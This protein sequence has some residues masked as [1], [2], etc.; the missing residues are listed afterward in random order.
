MSRVPVP[1]RDPSLSAGVKRSQIV[2]GSGHEQISSQWLRVEENA[3]VH[4]E[5][6]GGGG[7][8]GGRLVVRVGGGEG[9]VHLL[10]GAHRESRTPSAVVE[11]CVI[12]SGG[13]ET[14]LTTPNGHCRSILTL[15]LR[16]SPQ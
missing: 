14:E 3:E 11:C 10:D 8:G 13:V 7:R 5:L 16:K 2:S 12:A 15:L 1:V 4:L 6:P 9:G